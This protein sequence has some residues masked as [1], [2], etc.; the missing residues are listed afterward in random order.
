MNFK[1]DLF[2]FEHVHLASS[3]VAGNYDPTKPSG[4]FVSFSPPFESFWKKILFCSIFCLSL[5]CSERNID[6][7]HVLTG[8]EHRRHVDPPGMH[9]TSIVVCIRV[10]DWLSF[11]TTDFSQVASLPLHLADVHAPSWKHIISNF[12]TLSSIAHTAPRTHRSSMFSNPL[13][14]F[15]PLSLP[16]LS[17]FNHCD[18]CLFSQPTLLFSKQ[19]MERY[20][21][22]QS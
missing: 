20:G 22:G 12:T 7:V 9:K 17:D 19:T 5:S 14:C 1:H 4:M 8:L 11:L 21:K 16:W 2:R 15:E 10:N 18:D 6:L 13:G 3:D